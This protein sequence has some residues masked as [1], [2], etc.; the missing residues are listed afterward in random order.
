MDSVD[1]TPDVYCTWGIVFCLKSEVW[2]AWTQGILSA[3]AIFAAVG[4]AM[5]EH[6]AQQRS[7][8]LLYREAKRRV[9]QVAVLFGAQ[10]SYSLTALSDACLTRDM[11]V[12]MREKAVVDDMA[13]LARQIAMDLLPVQAAT[14]V[15][16]LRALCAYA[17]TAAAAAS[18]GVNLSGG[19]RE[20]HA[21]H[22]QAEA[23]C[24]R[25]HHELS[26]LAP[27]PPAP[28]RPEGVG[29]VGERP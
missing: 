7:A 1:S 29:P 10:L 14:T 28:F 17:R 22:R 13:S 26:D 16:N 5:H 15:I 18:D 25:L 27:E 12:I 11:D 23:Y 8:T 4:I 21:L 19:Y 2:A 20:F 6:R 24:Q 3:I 9:A